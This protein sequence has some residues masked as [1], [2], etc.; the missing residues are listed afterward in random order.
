MASAAALSVG[1]LGLLAASPAVR[2]QVSLSFT[3]QPERFTA[4][5]VTDPARLPTRVT[6][7]RPVSVDFGIQN[8]EGRQRRY[9]YVAKLTTAGRP[10]VTR[11]GAVEV[12]D[13]G[14]ASRRVDLGTAPR[15]SGYSVTVRLESTGET[16]RYRVGPGFAASNGGSK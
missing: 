3:H 10:A 4:L 11:R 16:I 6:P 5:Y 15:T 14:R 2:Q 13:S 7:G 9:R 8:H 12:A 1:L